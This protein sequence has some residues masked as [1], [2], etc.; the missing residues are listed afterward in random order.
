MLKNIILALCVGSIATQLVMATPVDCISR[1]DLFKAAAL[2]GIL[3]SQ[4][5]ATT[6]LPTIQF[7]CSGFLGHRLDAIHKGDFADM[8]VTAADEY[9]DLCT[10]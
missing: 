6:G 1:H 4:G 2:A 5:A 10:K 9:A 7:K 8:F 3:A